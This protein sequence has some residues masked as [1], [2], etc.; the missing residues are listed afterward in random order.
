MVWMGANDRQAFF[1]AS[2][3][4][5]LTPSCVFCTRIHN[6]QPFKPFT[7]KKD[8]RNNSKVS[9]ATTLPWPYSHHSDDEYDDD[10][11]EKMSPLCTDKNIPT[12]ITAARPSSIND[13]GK[14]FTLAD[15][16][17]DEVMIDLIGITNQIE[18]QERGYAYEAVFAI[19]VNI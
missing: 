13:T 12:E 8:P 11:K 14:K 6:N 9:P 2:D 15:D 1:G 3:N 7:M 19:K 16:D 5:I 17:E 18:L 4:D 10:D